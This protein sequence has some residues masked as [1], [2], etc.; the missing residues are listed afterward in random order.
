[1]QTYINSCKKM[2][3]LMDEGITK[4]YCGHYPYVKKAYNKQYIT[5]MRQLAESIVEGTAPEAKPHPQK[6]S[7]GSEHPMMVNLGEATIVYDPEHI[8]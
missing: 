3:K 4:I 5:E 1:M 8:N 2:E 7:I 6:V